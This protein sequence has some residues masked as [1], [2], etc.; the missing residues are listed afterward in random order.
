MA[1]PPASL[2]NWCTTGTREEPPAGLKESGW[3]I[4]EECPAEFMNWLQGNHGDWLSWLAFWAPP[5]CRVTRSAADDPGDV[6]WSTEEYDTGSYFTTDS[7][8]MLSVAHDGVYHLD[9]YIT[10][11]DAA[12]VGG[13]DSVKTIQIVRVAGAT[14]T[15]MAEST[16]DADSRHANC[17]ACSCDAWLGAGG[18]FKVVTA[19]DAGT[20]PKHTVGAF[21]IRWVGAPTW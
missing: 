12:I 14:E 10:L 18:Y 19:M 6:A 2:P 9:A 17:L 7:P 3:L 13:V 5:S 4:D 1:G 15:V 16:I 8:T 21:S 20:S 11:G